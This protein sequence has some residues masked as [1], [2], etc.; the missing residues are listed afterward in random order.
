MVFREGYHGGVLTFA[1]G[2]SE[3]NLP[4]PFVFA[5]YNDIE[6][7]RQ[8][9]GEVGDDLAAVIVE[10]MMGG[11]GCIPATAEFLSMLREATHASRRPCSSSTR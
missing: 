5:D 3:L 9:I 4:F 6:G 11:G 10:P 7:T 2:G 8:L 1:H